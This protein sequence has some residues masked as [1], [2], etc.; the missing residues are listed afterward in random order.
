MRWLDS[1][2]NSGDMS[3]SKLREIEDREAW[4]AAVHGVSKSDIAEHAHILYSNIFNGYPLL[5][6]IADLSTLYFIAAVIYSKDFIVVK[7][8]C[9]GI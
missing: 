6:V 5:V 7:F 1:I 2:I 3:L 8:P 9:E 4:H